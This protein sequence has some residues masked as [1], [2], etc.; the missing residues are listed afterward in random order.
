MLD[1]EDIKH[2]KLRAPPK[3]F[4]EQMRAGDKEGGARSSSAQGGGVDRASN[5]ENVG[6]DASVVRAL[7]VG[8]T[9]PS[10]GSGVE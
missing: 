9:R 8:E 6:G 3:S 5:V 2:P 10:L 4:E 7:D 1:L